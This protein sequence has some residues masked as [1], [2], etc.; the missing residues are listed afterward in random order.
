[1]AQKRRPHGSGC[2]ISTPKGL[3]IRWRETIVKNGKGRRALRQ[4]LQGFITGL[5]RFGYAPHSIHHYYEVLNAVLRTAVSWNHIGENP[6]QA[7][8]LPKTVPKRPKAVL[9]PTEAADLLL[10]LPIST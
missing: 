4:R 2:V 7:V 1:M 9:T 8:S 5:N 6:A 3:A 10:A